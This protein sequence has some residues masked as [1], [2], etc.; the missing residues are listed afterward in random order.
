MISALV[1]KF[2]ALVFKVVNA[3]STFFGF[4]DYF[5]DPVRLQLVTIIALTSGGVAKSST[6]FGVRVTV[7]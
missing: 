5:K 7:S 6:K 1:T 3:N 2:E 4:G